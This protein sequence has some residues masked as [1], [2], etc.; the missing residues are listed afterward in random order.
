[1]KSYGAKGDGSTDDTVAVQRA[2]AEERVVYIPGG[3]YRLTDGLVIRENCE[4]ELAQDAVLQ[5]EQTEGNAITLLRLA[6][7]KGNHATIFVPYTFSGNV[8]N[9]DTGDDEAALDY[10]RTITDAEALKDAQHTANNDAVPPFKKW[11]PQWRMSRYVTDVNICKRIETKWH[12]NCY[13]EDGTCYGTAVNLH[14]DEADYAS[15]MWGVSMSGIRISGGFNYGIHA[16]NTGDH[17]KSWN[18]DMRIEAVIENCKIGVLIDNCYY[19]RFAVTIQARCARD[20]TPYAEHG[21]KIVSSQGIDLS[22]SRVWDWENVNEAGNT[23]NSLWAKGNEYQHIALYGNCQGLILD[24]FL[25]HK[26]SDI[27]EHIFVEEGYEANFDTMT[28]LQDPSNKW[29]RAKDGEPY[30]YDGL[31]ETKLLTKGELDAYFKVDTVKS[32]EDVLATATD[33][34]GVTIFNEIGYQI[35]T[36]FT[37]YGEDSA[38]HPSVGY[39]MVTGFIEVP[40]GATVYCKDLKFA[41]TDLTYSCIVFYDADRVKVKNINIGHIAANTSTDF[42]L[43]YVETEDGCSFKI[44]SRQSLTDLGYKYL[45]ICFPLPDVGENPMIAIDEPIKYKAE[46]FLGDGVK[47]KGEAVVLTS[48]GGKAYTLTVSDTG[49]LTAVAM[50]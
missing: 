21:I 20:N 43:E 30:F 44:S 23:I 24:D 49:A 42:V 28:I 41:R 36:R 47:V 34:D 2:L 32:F 1:M 25:C 31:G 40:Q 46:G 8:L 18:H 50:E 39:Y 17:M 26:V 38:L 16:H 33:T 13:S 14:C 11:D 27:R 19:S 9:A 48:A 4:L 5:F 3:T 45:R 37:S 10:D 12:E 29:F 7:L 35:D 15:Y 22:S 6:S